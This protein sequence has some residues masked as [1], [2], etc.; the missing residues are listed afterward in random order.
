MKNKRIHYLHERYARGL[1]SYDELDELKSLL[2]DQGD[3]SDAAEWADQVWE[4]LGQAPLTDISE[5]RRAAIL[6]RIWGRKSGRKRGRRIIVWSAAAVMIISSALLYQY[7]M[8]A[9]EPA[10]IVSLVQTAVTDIEPGTDKAVLTLADGRQVL[11]D[12][13]EEQQIL[14]DPSLQ[15]SK[16][17]SDMLV[18]IPAQAAPL[19]PGGIVEYNTLRT[20]AGGQYQ[21]L[22]PDGTK[23]TLNASSRLRYPQRFPEGNRLVEFEGEGYFEVM[24]D[25]SRPFVVKTTTSGIAQEVRVLGTA[26]N[27]NSYDHAEAVVT[28]VVGGRVAVNGADADQVLLGSGQQSVFQ[29]L[30]HAPPTLYSRS[31][32]LNETMA[33]KDGLFVFNNETL[34]SLLKR[35]ARWYDVVF[36][37]EED[38]ADIMFQGNYFRNK[39]LLNLLTNLETTGR[40]QFRIDQT[41]T[42][43]RRIYVMRK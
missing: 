41:Y 28:T 37:Y 15:I 19:Q 3:E 24:P 6:D 23:V 35:V 9:N 16:T 31:A 38:L 2:V 13:H 20:P 7:W 5:G 1:A 14:S 12:G 17:A 18:Y 27:I 33:W 36:V 21:V 42:D 34:P 39:G 29:R 22:L 40:I 32:D 43:E 8:P 10:E 30:Q 25:A 26:F 4:E 11:L